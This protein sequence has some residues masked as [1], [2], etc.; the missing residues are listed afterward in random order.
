V[1]YMIKVKNS[2]FLFSISVYSTAKS[3]KG[4]HTRCIAII[5]R[6]LDFSAETRVKFLPEIMD[7]RHV[8]VRN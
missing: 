4:K 7:F 2:V 1:L 3:V 8:R 6:M 5:S